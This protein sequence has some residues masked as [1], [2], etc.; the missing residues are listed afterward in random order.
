MLVFRN[1]AILRGGIVDSRDMNDLITA[2][3]NLRQNRCYLLCGKVIEGII[4]NVIVFEDTYIIDSQIMQYLDSLEV[5]MPIK[6]SSITCDEINE[7]ILLRINSIA[8][9][10]NKNEPINTYSI[11]DLF[12]TKS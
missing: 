3:Y 5:P 2:I 6:T 4:D 10:L 9:L 12:N 7:A 8:H 1:G 11:S